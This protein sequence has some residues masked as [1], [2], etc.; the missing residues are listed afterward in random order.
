MQ[1]ISPLEILKNGLP[2]NGLPPLHI[3]V[4]GAGMAGLTSA[5]LLQ[6]AGHKVTI[7][8][9][10]NRL[11]GRIFTYHGFPGK[12]YGEFG[13]MRFPRQHKLAQYLINERF[14]LETRPFPMYDEDT[15]IY[16]D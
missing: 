9:A 12:M 7:L 16:L 4:V 5:L 1:A 8:E 6:E 14:G 15:L 13:A 2:D 3:V 10:K 11:G